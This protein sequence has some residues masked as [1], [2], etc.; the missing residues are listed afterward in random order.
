MIP[1][2]PKNS[3]SKV[4][5]SRR[6]AMTEEE[7]THFTKNRNNSPGEKEDGWSFFIRLLAFVIFVAFPF[8]EIPDE[9]EIMRDWQKPMTPMTDWKNFIEKDLFLN[10]IFYL[11]RFDT[12]VRCIFSNS[13]PLICTFVNDISMLPRIAKVVP[14]SAWFVSYFENLTPEGLNLIHA[15]I[16]L[17]FYALCMVFIDKFN[18]KIVPLNGSNVIGFRHVTLI[19]VYVFAYCHYLDDDVPNSFFKLSDVIARPPVS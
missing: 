3:T 17:F 10:P 16:G 14:T 7:N 11:S 6:R 5:E 4:A 8:F 19:L 1:K 2:I 12:F 13:K 9:M 15:L 18:R